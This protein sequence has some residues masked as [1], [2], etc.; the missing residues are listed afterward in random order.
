MRCSTGSTS[1]RTSRSSAGIRINGDMIEQH[2]ARTLAGLNASYRFRRQWRELAFETTFGTQLRTDASTTA[3]STTGPASA[4]AR[5]WTPACAQGSLGLYAQEDI[6]FTPWL[7]AV[8]GLR[9][10]LFG[11]DVEDQLEDLATQD[12]KTSGVRQASTCLAQG[13]PRLRRHSQ[14]R[15]VPQLRVAAF[16][17]TTRAGW[18]ASPTPVTPLTQAR[19]YELGAR[20]R[21]FDA[22]GSG[23]LALP[24][25]PGQRAGVGRGRGHHGGARPHAAARPGGGGAAAHPAVALRGRG[26]HGVTSHLRGERGERER[27]GAGADAHPG[28]E[29]CPR[30]TRAAP[31]AASE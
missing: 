4:S 6:T 25:G 2:D 16:T 28:A 21:L 30:G 8:L 5:W 31:M 23:R 9:G 7:R 1:S 3:S 19:G 14:D 18:C 26:P 12:T 13:E 17:P 20:T 11:F 15:A 10:D 24:A 22:A 29:A 27:G